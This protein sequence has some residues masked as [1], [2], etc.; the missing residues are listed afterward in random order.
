MD[1]STY[2]RPGA[3][4][5]AGTGR[6]GGHLADER[7]HN[8]R[9]RACSDGIVASIA[10]AHPRAMAARRRSRAGGSPSRPGLQ[11][12]GAEDAAD[13][14]TVAVGV[15]VAV[16]R[17]RPRPQQ[18]QQQQ[19]LVPRLLASPPRARK[20]GRCGCDG[21][22]CSCSC[23]L[24]LLRL[25]AVGATPPRR[26]RRAPGPRCCDG[27]ARRSARPMADHAHLISAAGLRGLSDKLYERRKQAALEVE[28][29][30]KQLAERNDMPKVCQVRSLGPLTPSSARAN[31]PRTRPS[32]RRPAGPASEHPSA[33]EH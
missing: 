23:S 26:R 21:C 27:A 31:P 32:R 30:V 14:D 18:Q 6:A 8:A 22:C 4:V 29:T 20:G 19:Q 16:G 28:A 25:A 33:S 17:P 10:V 9:A 24:S 7:P 13:A 2:P 1:L 15:V 11:E 5:Q 3:R 12:G